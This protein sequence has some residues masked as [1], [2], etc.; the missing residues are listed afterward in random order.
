MLSAGWPV[1][2]TNQSGVT[3]LHW[4]AFH[5]N[6]SVVRDLLRQGASVLVRDLTFKGAPTGWAEHGAQ[7]SWNRESGDYPAVLQALAAAARSQ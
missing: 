3:A 4:A 1:N 7:N 5:G 6:A 2:A